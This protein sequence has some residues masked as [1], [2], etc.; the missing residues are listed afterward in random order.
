MD[1]F[2][3][4]ERARKRT[5]LLIFY[6]VMAVLGI[7][8]AVYAL[9]LIFFFT[10]E[11]TGVSLFRLDALAIAVVGSIGVI[12][13]GSL[14][15][16]WQLSAGGSAVAK[17]LGGR[18]IDRNTTDPAERQLM[19]V[20]EEM[21]IASGVPMPDVYLLDEASINAFAA[22]KTTSDAVIGVTRGCMQLLNRD[23]LQGVMA[24]EFSH[25]LNGDMRINLRLMGLLFGIL[26]LTVIGRVVMRSSLYARGGG[27]SNRG[28][29]AVALLAFGAGLFAIGSIGILF[30]R[31]IQA[32]VSRQRE[33]LADASAVQFTRLP[34]GIAGALKKI[35]GLSAGSRLQHP[36]AEEASH[37][38]FAG[39]IPSAMSGSFATHPPLPARIKAIDPG[40]DG[41]F[42]KIKDGS[43]LP[44]PGPTR[45]PA[46][47]AMV[48]KL[49]GGATMAAGA[50]GAAG[51]RAASVQNT[52]QRGALELNAGHLQ[53][54]HRIRQHLPEPVM[55][56]V[57][58]PEGA[59]EVVLAVL[60]S[61][62]GDQLPAAD[63]KVL[64]QRLGK[65]ATERITG[66]RAH[67][68]PL[69][70][71]ERLAMIDLTFPS[72]RRMS[73]AD[74]RSFVDTMR[75][76]MAA[77]QQIDLFEFTVERMVER[78]LDLFFN[79]RRAHPVRVRKLSQIQRELSVLVSTLAGVGS[80]D[81]D[82]QRHAFAIGARALAEHEPGL[83]I[84]HLGPEH[85]A[86]DV[87]GRA[88][89]RCDEATP[90]LKKGILWACGKVVMAD[91]KVTDMEAELLRAIADAMGCPMPPFVQT[92]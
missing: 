67:L 1:F 36:R 90:L 68:A 29:G 82:E 83:R 19:N 13:L 45:S 39:G 12:G 18:L 50:A 6:Y 21:A 54:A 79:P 30:G 65:P 16:T 51:S 86:L 84:D 76:V 42:P 70:S 48:S 60:L 64:E 52:L 9:M 2:E 62:A 41:S 47:A 71:A 87:V 27:R 53:E 55:Q 92:A 22:G 4:Q 85:C 8:A 44:V 74:Y 32:A 73:E 43:S 11:D 89:E 66:L 37:M 77:D 14:F 3:A 23:E 58:T 7:I 81:A 49:A 38:Y 91:D 46:A 10:Q 24:H 25:I 26:M 88:L 28:G 80:G 59:R 56:Q 61:R 75:A 69:P 5:K 15:K 57:N 20:V 31:L 72:L 17:E 63:V 40:W 34:D 35:G 78:H 33:F